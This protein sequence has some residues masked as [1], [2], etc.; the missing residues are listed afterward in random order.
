MARYPQGG[1]MTAVGR[2]KREQVRMQAAQWF[3]EGRPNARIAA[4]LRVGLRQVEKWRRAWREGGAEALRSK[5]PH[6]RPRLDQA[7]FAQL[8]AELNRGPAAHGWAHDQRWTLDRVAEVIRRLFGID[9]TRPGVSLLLRRNGWS[10]QV[11]GRRAIERNDRAIEVWKEQVWPQ[12]ETPRRT[13]APGSA[14]KMR[15]VRGSSRPKDAPGAAGD[16]DPG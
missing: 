4:D 6:G 14:S 2:D 16:T 3:T 7:A 8:E 5:G 1:G 9:Y 15:P 10:V 12:V 13:W 11:P